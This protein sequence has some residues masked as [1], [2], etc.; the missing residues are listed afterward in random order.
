MP[1]AAWVPS[2]IGQA[3]NPLEILVE[4]EEEEEAPTPHSWF[5]CYLLFQ[6]WA[7]FSSIRATSN[8]RCCDP[9]SAVGL[10]NLYS[11]CTFPS[12]NTCFRFYI[13]LLKYD[14]L[15][16]DLGAG[17]YSMQKAENIRELINLKPMYVLNLFAAK[18]CTIAAHDINTRTRSRGSAGCGMMSE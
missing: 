13:P 7:D 4:E 17:T 11:S 9:P 3:E 1:C 8:L 18:F 6:E 5:F 10:A 16:L 15:L 14:R 2:N 12:L